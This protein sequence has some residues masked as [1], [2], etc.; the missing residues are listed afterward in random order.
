MNSDITV[1]IFEL[2]EEIHSL[3]NLFIE[4]RN[5]DLKEKILIAADNY[6]SF[7]KNAIHKFKEENQEQP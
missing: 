6:Y 4:T 5:P 3:Y 1:K 2:Q 7:K